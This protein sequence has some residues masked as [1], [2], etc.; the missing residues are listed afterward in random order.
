MFQTFVFSCLCLLYL[1]GAFCVEIYETHTI[2]AM[3]GDSVILHTDVTDLQ[4][5]NVLL[6]TFGPQDAHI[7]KI[8]RVHNEMF[9]NGADGRFRDRLELDSQTGSL[10]ITNVSTEL[11][12]LYKVE[13][14][15]ENKVSSKNF[16]VKVYAHLPIPVITRYCPQN[17]PSSVSRYELLCS[18]VNVSRVTLSWYKGNSLLSSINVSDISSSVSLHLEVE[19]QDNNT[20][21]CVLNN[22]ISNQTQHPDITQLCQIHSDDYVHYYGFTEAVIRL[23]LSALV[24]VAAVA[25][26]VYDVN[27]R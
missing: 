11:N 24:G 3:E 26:L 22:P 7:A 25:V 5:D 18:V 9:H 10:T 13:I 19:Y 1:T 27:S 17:P 2:S 12:G 23:A 14:V 21:S 6:W 20:Y 4:R 15:I 16:I 8:N